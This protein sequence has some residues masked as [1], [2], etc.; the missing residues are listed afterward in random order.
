MNG[1]PRDMFEEM[2]E[3]FDHLFSR[4][5]QDLQN[6][7]SQVSGF[8]IIIESGNPPPHV[9]DTPSVPLRIAASP[10]AEVHRLD[11]E[12][13]VIAELPGAARD[14]I[15]LDVQGLVLS[16]DADGVNTPYHTTAKLPPVDTG[17]MQSTFR[18]GVLEVTFRAL[19]TG[20]ASV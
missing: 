5:N 3:I 2:D 4:M 15:R 6:S 17:S 1:Y 10:V 18:N 7:G 12:V 19:D 11:D 9:Q 14:N 13:K 8:R 16:I 20:P